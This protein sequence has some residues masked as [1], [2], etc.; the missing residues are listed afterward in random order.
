MPAIS[1]ANWIDQRMSTSSDSVHPLVKMYVEYI[2]KRVLHALHGF[3]PFRAIQQWLAK[4]NKSYRHCDDDLS[5]DSC[6]FPL[7]GQ[8]STLNRRDERTYHLWLCLHQSFVRLIG[9][10]AREQ[11]I[12]ADGLL[13]STCSRRLKTWTGCHQYR[14]HFQTLHHYSL[15]LEPSLVCDRFWTEGR[16]GWC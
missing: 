1:S 8:P 14:H 3:F 5:T 10:Q 4:L 15:T 2:L 16:S 11:L 13:A 12:P 7:I 9:I 6:W